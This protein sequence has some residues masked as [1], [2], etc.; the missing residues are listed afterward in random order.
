MARQPELHEVAIEMLFKDPE[1]PVG[2]WL[3]HKAANVE[4]IAKELLLIPGSGR[5]YTQYVFTRLPGVPRGTPG[6]LGFWG[7]RPPHVASAP[8]MPPAS[9]TGQYMAKIH[10]EV[11]VRDTA[12]GRVGFPSPLVRWLNYGTVYM[13]PRPHVE[14]ALEAG[15]RMP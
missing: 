3:D 13:D 4:T 8:G 6:R 12:V 11:V 2:R 1:G 10:H 14:P 9:D 15:V 7:H 5:L